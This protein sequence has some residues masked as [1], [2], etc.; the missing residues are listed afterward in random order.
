MTQQIEPVFQVQWRGFPRSQWEPYAQFPTRA[1]AEQFARQERADGG[2]F[3]VVE[4]EATN[5]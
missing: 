5:A 3:R 2:E 4:R 1:E